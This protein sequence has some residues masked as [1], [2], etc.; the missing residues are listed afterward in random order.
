M[1]EMGRLLGPALLVHRQRGPVQ[2]GRH[3]A[4]V[5]QGTLSDQQAEDASLLRSRNDG[6]G[7]TQH[8]FGPLLVPRTTRG[9]WVATAFPQMGLSVTCSFCLGSGNISE[10][11]GSAFLLLRGE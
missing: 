2:I 6:D 3:L 10:A 5:H 1:V 9:L 11:L 7:G 4:T 8:A